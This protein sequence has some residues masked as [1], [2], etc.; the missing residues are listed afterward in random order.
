MIRPAGPIVFYD[1]QCGLC[2]RSVR[3]I[4]HHDRHQRL[5]FAPLQGTTYAALDAP[6]K[7]TDEGTI[8]LLDADGLHVRSEAVLRILRSI[9]GPWRAL[10][11][12]G[13]LC[14]RPVRDAVYRWV[15]RHRMQWFGAVD[16][17][18]IPSEDERERFLG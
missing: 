16:A 11:V 1:G 12:A 15:A 18:E 9:G 4:L 14:P 5:R 8:V 10:A 7:P 3:W 2:D 13:R 6:S 17:C